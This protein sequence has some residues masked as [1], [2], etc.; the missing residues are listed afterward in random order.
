MR[1]DHAA[2]ISAAAVLSALLGTLG[3]LGSCPGADLFTRYG[4]AKALF[5]DPNV[6]G[7]FLILPAMY[8][9]AARAAGHA[10]GARSGPASCS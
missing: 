9:A 6:F 5:N 3:Y 10:A 1:L 7:P 8:R 4:R 2:P